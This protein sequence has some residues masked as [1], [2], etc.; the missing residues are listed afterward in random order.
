[1]LL[2]VAVVVEVI[3]MQKNNEVALESNIG[4]HHVSMGRQRRARS[5]GACKLVRE[6]QLTNKQTH[7]DSH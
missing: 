7:S 3:T 4:G 6:N 1:M 5:L 2:V